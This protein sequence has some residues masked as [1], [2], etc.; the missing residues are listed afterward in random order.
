[1][2]KVYGSIGVCENCLKTRRL[3]CKVG[4]FIFCQSCYSK[5]RLRDPKKRDAHRAAVRRWERK[6][7]GKIRKYNREYA[8]KRTAKKRQLHGGRNSR[9]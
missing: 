6:N 3:H 8:R 2:A 9:T 7:K 5:N 1:M 4:E